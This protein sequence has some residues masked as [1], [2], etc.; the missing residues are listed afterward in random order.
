MVSRSPQD[1]TPEPEAALDLRL[2]RR[3]FFDLFGRSP[4]AEER[5]RFG[6]LPWDRLLTALIG[7]ADFWSAWYETELFYFLLLDNFRPTTERLVTLPQRLHAGEV[8]VRHA[9]QEIVGS[10]FFNARNPGPDTFVS[11]LWEQLLG[12]VVQDDPRLLARGKRMY[13]GERLT[14]FGRAGQSQ[15]DL[16][17]L[18]VEQPEF[19]SFYLQRTHRRLAGA[20]RGPRQAKP[21]GERFAED[22]R[23]FKDILVGW[24][25]APAYRESTKPRLKTDEM[26]LR[27]LFVDVLGRL[28]DYDEV[29]NLRNAIQAFADPTPIRNVLTRLILGSPE[30]SWDGGA[31]AEWVR[32]TFDHLLGRSPEAEELE[33]FLSA[34]TQRNEPRRLVVQALVTSREY[35]YY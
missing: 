30:R 2:R 18:T 4:L 24:L 10:Q 22:P 13:D 14:L 32:S 7:R 34:V 27:G 25:N 26:F 9:I 31:D 17:R 15:A 33:G 8:D 19:A 23:Q 20:T 5:R 21:E 35:Q 3:L 11:V 16:V 29:R 6:I 1:T 12:R 28:P